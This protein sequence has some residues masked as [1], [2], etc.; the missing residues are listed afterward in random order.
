MNPAPISR[1]DFNGYRSD[2]VGFL[3]SSRQ[4]P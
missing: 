4:V 1:A 2:T 3:L